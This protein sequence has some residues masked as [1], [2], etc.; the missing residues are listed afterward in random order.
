M[1]VDGVLRRAGILA[2]LHRYDAADP[3]LAQVLAGEP[4]NEE[5]LSLLG[6]GLFQR[7]RFQEAADVTGHLLRVNP[8]NLQGLLR[9]A[10]VMTVLRRA[11]E[12]VPFGRRAVELHP[13][14]PVCL[15][16]LAEILNEVTPG[17]AEA[18]D[19]AERAV[20]ID[21]EYADAHRLI[22]KIHLDIW[23][24]A[25]AERATLQALR[26][27]PAGSQ[28][29]LQ[30]GLARAG[31]GRFHESRDQVLAALRLN[32]APEAIDAVI[33]QIECRGIPGHFAEI[34]RM[35]LAARGLPDLSHPGAAGDDPELLAAQGKLANRM[36]V[37]EA[38]P[39]GWRRAGELA[40][41]VLAG[42]PGNQ[43]ARRVRS[44]ELSISGRYEQ[45]LAT[46]E[47]LLAEDYPDADLPL[48]R[49]RLGLGDYAGALD[50]ARRM[51]ASDPDRVLYLLIESRCLRKMGRYEEALR[52]ALRA[53]RLVDSGPD[54]QLELGRAAKGTGDIVLAERA[55]RSAVAGAPGEGEPPGELALLLAGVG[56][57]AEAE[58]VIAELPADVPD[59]DQVAA[60]CAQIGA[61]AV[62]RAMPSLDT[63][64][65]TDDPDP[66]ALAECA[67]WLG[68]GARMW[69]AM[70][71]YHPRML[72]SL[73]RL[74]GA[75]DILR[76]VPAPPESDFARVVRD[77][78][79]LLERRRAA[80]PPSA[81]AGGATAQ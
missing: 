41:A 35:A 64:T 6:H 38:G 27:D 76:T 81:D 10:L 2:D 50:A 15:T 29:V 19:L 77:Y 47:Q 30:L 33:N 45:A 49:A 59:G 25:D 3:L 44:L 34:Y 72:A 52:S 11:R 69:T 48:A 36:Y 43:D 73:G 55:L 68:L 46:A 63:I 53:A 78:G 62:E 28:A 67:H 71:N 65:G 18:M 23:R 4:D 61:L 32:A 9:M 17:S 20:A 22:G 16:R 58:A 26:I 70:A 24:Y 54:V 66:G 1:A 13:G 21:P 8:D 56:R 79:T 5:A 60:R 74:P 57:W 80:G 12:G 7:K 31:L 40:A 75:V 37:R 39:D 14:A 42:D 51:L